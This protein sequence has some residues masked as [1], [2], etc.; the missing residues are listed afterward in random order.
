[1]ACIQWCPENAITFGGKSPKG[2]GAYTH[3]D[4]SATD[5]ING[6]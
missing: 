4:I 3:P 2:K 6:R 5:I 1:M